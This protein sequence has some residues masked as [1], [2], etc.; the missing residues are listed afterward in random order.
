M[1]PQRYE[2][3]VVC[4]CVCLN[5]CSGRNEK[6]LNFLVALLVSLS[7]RTSSARHF[8]S[9]PTLIIFS[10]LSSFHRVRHHTVSHFLHSVC[11]SPSLQSRLVAIKPR[12]DADSRPRAARWIFCKIFELNF[13]LSLAS[14]LV[15]TAQPL[16]QRT[17]AHLLCQHRHQHL[18]TQDQRLN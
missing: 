1:S 16:I 6:L 12:S 7:T 13:L 10:A 18:D 5:R 4:V 14:V 2:N 15:V 9:Q 8:I 3:T 11:L 17:H